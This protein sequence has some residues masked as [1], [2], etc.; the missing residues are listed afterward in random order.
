LSIFLFT[1]DISLT[2]RINKQLKNPCHL[3][4]SL[5]Q[6]E[7]LKSI[8]TKDSHPV[9]LIDDKFQK[10]NVSGIIKYIISSEIYGPKIII[11]EDIKMGNQM[12]FVHDT[13]IGF[14]NSPFTIVELINSIIDISG[15]A[16][17]A[18]HLTKEQFENLNPKK[19]AEWTSSV[20]VGE[21][22]AICKVREII[23]IIGHS[24]SIVHI[25]GE[26]GTGKEVV[27]SLLREA[28]PCPDPW[29]PVNCA[30]LSP[31][32]ADATLFGSK[33]GAYTDAKEDRIGLIKSADGGILFL[34]EIEDLR[35]SLQGKLL[36]FLETRQFRALGCTSFD[37]SSFR[38]ITASNA[39]FDK[40]LEE[41]RIRLD[42]V[43]RINTLEITLPPLRDR[44]EDIPLLVEFY[45]NKIGEHRRPDKPTM[46]KILD[47]KW[48]GNIRE[49]FKE[50][51]QL[52]IFSSPQS[53]ELSGGE[54]LTSSILN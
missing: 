14:L 10:L 49:L 12:Q 31:Y 37:S 13:S 54:I 25:T 41:G 45:L 43:S 39:P 23:D 4:S 8:I 18:P 27:A 15:V 26:T 20:L 32:I 38:L 28:S 36:R 22:K 5:K 46:Q 2:N 40:L 17:V 19:R 35:P 6:F 29:V 7:S 30:T 11:T 3:I 47:A 16:A 9:F 1:Q 44:R 21:S 48:L 33:R 53:E 24:F 42:L 52:V 51:D 50:L 34:D